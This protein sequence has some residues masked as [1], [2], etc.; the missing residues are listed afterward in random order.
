MKGGFVF[1]CFV[2][3]AL[4]NATS[5]ARTE[6]VAQVESRCSESSVRSTTTK[7]TANTQTYKTED[8]AK[9]DG[10]RAHMKQPPSN[11]I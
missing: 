7:L 4:E 5:L 2:A 1:L 11:G 3:Q 6:A 8:A 10:R 9:Y